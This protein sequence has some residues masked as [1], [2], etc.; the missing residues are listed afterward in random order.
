[1]IRDGSCRGF[2]WG[3]ARTRLL[4]AVLAVLLAGYTASAQLTYS[5][6]QNIS[7]AFEGWEKNADGSFNFLFGYM[8]RNWVEEIDLPVG[9]DN[10]IG[11]GPADQGQPTHFYPRRNRFVFKVRVPKDFAQ[12]ELI[13]T[14]T[15]HGKTERA[16][17]TLK[18]D[19]FIDDQI[20]ASETGAI[21][22]G[23][24]TPESRGNKAPAIVLEGGKSRTA[25][26]GEPLTLIASVTDDGL[27]KAFSFGRGG[28]GA[29]PQGR[30]AGAPATAPREGAPSAPSGA[31]AP[32][33]GGGA[34]VPGFPG[35]GN[36]AFTPPGQLTVNK[37]LGL[38]LSWF[39]YRGAADRITFNPEQI[40]TWENSRVGGNS[41]WSPLWTNPPL[42]ADGKWR[43]QVTFS[44]P[45][46][47]VLRSRADDGGLY[48]D[49][50]VTVTVA[51]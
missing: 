33:P 38:H 46:T 1:M 51:R 37:A 39:V 23:I 36:P 25:K 7:P 12:Q 49:E 32:A 18:S 6:G 22:A 50:E 35:R 19:F 16:Y 45:G 11:P 2:A 43:T 14:L 28:G 20:I 29:P 44:Q 27:P 31:S 26:A 5:K 42:P 15:A 34:P 10:N 40:Q 21:G 17:G 48:A 4:L 13:W 3:A 24:T 30:G 47:Y 41:P 9:P 8:N